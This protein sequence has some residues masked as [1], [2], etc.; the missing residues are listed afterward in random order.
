[1]THATR[2]ESRVAVTDI[3][4]A[5]VVRPAALMFPELESDA[6]VRVAVGDVADR[7]FC[8]SLVSGADDLSVF[9]LGAM[10]SGQGEEEFDRCLATNLHGTMN[11]LE[12][13]R[14]TAA[15][16][17]RCAPQLLLQAPCLLSRLYER[18]TG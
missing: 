13:A 2:G 18:P 5:D 7:A 11:L 9:H 3:V 10:M 12:A 16:R 15:L 14:H 8:D 1:M 6:S 17:P 4:L